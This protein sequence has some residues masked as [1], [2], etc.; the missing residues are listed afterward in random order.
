MFAKMFVVVVV[1]VAKIVA[2]FGPPGGAC[3]LGTVE[4]KGP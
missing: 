2:W 3:A 1:V 4:N